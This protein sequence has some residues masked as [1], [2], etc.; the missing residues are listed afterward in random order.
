[1]TPFGMEVP[2][3]LKNFPCRIS[4]TKEQYF[5]TF[6]DDQGFDGDS[7]ESR[8]Y[9]VASVNQTLLRMYENEVDIKRGRPTHRSMIK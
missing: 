9:P 1:M 7:L 3:P 8:G 6:D 5:V 2:P 4:F